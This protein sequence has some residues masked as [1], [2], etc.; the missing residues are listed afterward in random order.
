VLDL[1]RAHILALG[2]LAERSAVYNLGCGGN[3]YTVRE[4]I[5]TARTITGCPIPVCE[6]ARRPGDPAV[7]IA[8]SDKIKR[9][10][11][12]QPQHQ[13]LEIIIASAWDWLKRHPK[14]YE[15]FT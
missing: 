14:G 13:K 4:V 2:I 12:W 9:E 8:S 7:L 11:G 1:A 6:S 15:I 10:L 3:G 5:E